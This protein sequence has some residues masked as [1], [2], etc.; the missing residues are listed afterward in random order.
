MC[1]AA[2]FARQR[3]Q[4]VRR[5]ASCD[6]VELVERRDIG[7]SGGRGLRGYRAGGPVRD[8]NERV[9]P[10]G[11]V[12]VGRNGGPVRP[13]KACEEKCERKEGRQKAPRGITHLPRH[14]P[15]YSQP[16]YYPP[17]KRRSS[18]VRGVFAQANDRAQGLAAGRR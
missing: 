1:I 15:P 2:R 5:E 3:A 11:E 14:F 9:V 18:P 12:R 6:E 7:R 16:Q 13:R 17:T 8:L 10:G 4:R